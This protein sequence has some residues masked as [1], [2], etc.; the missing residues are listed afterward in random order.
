MSNQLHDRYQ[1]VF[2]YDIHNSN[3][4]NLNALYQPPHIISSSTTQ[5]NKS[6]PANLSS[7]LQNQQLSS[8][9][10]EINNMKS[11]IEE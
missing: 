5:L 10:A 7:T 8:P 11:K 3:E 2:N 4:T 6:P 9:P 1:S